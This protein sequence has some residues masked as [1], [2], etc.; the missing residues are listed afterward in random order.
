MTALIFDCDGVLV[1]SEPLSVAELGRALREIGARVSDAEIAG[2]MIGLSTA[3]ILA[4]LRAEEGL[5]AAPALPRFRARLAE[6][7][8]RELRPIPGIAEAIRALEALPRIVASSSE[9]ERI[10]LSLRV[11]GLADLFGPRICSA[12]EVDHGKPAPDLFLLAAARLGVPPAACIV[13]EDSTAGIR[14]AQAAGM[15]VVGFMGGSH[16]QA[17]A[18]ATR[19]PALHPDALASRAEELPGLIAGLIGS[20]DKTAGGSHVSRN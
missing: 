15:R 10:A 1:D 9:P 13:I 6:R 18:L 11:T 8:A 20:Q 3:S 17:C 5:D 19:L 4:L 14:A 2:R 7:L 12:V 16:A